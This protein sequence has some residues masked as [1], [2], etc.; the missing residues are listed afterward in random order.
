MG[1]KEVG[2]WEAIIVPNRLRLEGKMREMD[3]RVLA[4]RDSVYDI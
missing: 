2:L 1:R 3:D 4:L